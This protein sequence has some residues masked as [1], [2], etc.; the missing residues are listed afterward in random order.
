MRVLVTESQYLV[1]I[2]GNFSRLRTSLKKFPTRKTEYPDHIQ[3]LLRYFSTH[4]Q[5]N[6][7]TGRLYIFFYFFLVTK[8][9]KYKTNINYLNLFCLRLLLVFGIWVFLPC[10]FADCR[11]GTYHAMSE[12]RDAAETVKG[13]QATALEKKSRT[14]VRKIYKG[15]IFMR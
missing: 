11:F 8:F 14:K 9:Y 15:F 3:A 7:T 1:C 12:T 5:T 13:K 4:R 2:A 6:T 10:L